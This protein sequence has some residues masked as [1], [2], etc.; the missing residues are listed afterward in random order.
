MKKTEINSEDLK[1]KDKSKIINSSYKK[2]YFIFIGIIIFVILFFLSL[3]LNRKSDTY[4]LAKKIMNEYEDI[5]NYEKDEALPINEKTKDNKYKY[6]Y[7]EASL[8]EIS[9]SKDGSKEV[10]IG[11]YKYNSQN[12]AKAKVKFIKNKYKILHK[13]IDNTFLSELDEYTSLFDKEKNYIFYVDNYVIEINSD[14]SAYNKRLR[15]FITKNITKEKSKKY[16][17]NTK[18]NRYWD[19]EINKFSQKY[20]TVFNKELKKT[21]NNILKYQNKLDS[22]TI[23]IC[24]KIYDDVIIFE[25]YDDLKD[26]IEKFKNKYNEIMISVID[27]SNISYDDAVNWCNINKLKSCFISSEYSND[28]E[29]GKLISQS[30][31]ESEIIRKSD[32]I[33]LVYSKGKEPSLEY[34]NA[35]KSANSYLNAMPFSYL[36]LIDQLEYENYPHDAAVYAADNCGADWNEQAAKSA[37]QYLNTMSFSHSGLVE[38]LIYEKFTREQAEYGVSQAGL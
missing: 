14:F 15:K 34:R 30:V 25:K 4:I 12:E 35:L 32:K 8:I 33:E 29:K 6:S 5:F 13:Y 21:K 28:I 26:E 16:I 36:G 38:Q 31:K 19:S 27:F 17:S 18:I 1:L 9:S 3:Y 37:K 24:K 10:K 23:E 11:I 20:E 2:I 7:I 22:C